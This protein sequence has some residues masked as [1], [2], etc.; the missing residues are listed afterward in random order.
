M[1][2][3]CLLLWLSSMFSCKRGSGSYRLGYPGGIRLELPISFYPSELFRR[4]GGKRKKKPR[5]PLEALYK[6][7]VEPALKEEAFLREAAW[8]RDFL[9][10]V[11]D[12]CVETACAFFYL[13]CRD[14]SI[15]TGPVSL[16]QVAREEEDADALLDTVISPTQTLSFQS[17][18][19]DDLLVLM[20]ALL[21]GTGTVVGIGRESQGQLRLLVP[22]EPEGCAL[23]LDVQELSSDGW[24][25]SAELVTSFQEEGFMDVYWFPDSPLVE[26]VEPSERPELCGE[27]VD[28]LGKWC[29]ESETGDLQKRI[30]ASILECLF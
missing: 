6:R 3:L 28:I 23:L 24:Q 25:Q 29:A 4:G 12:P 21:H 30:C 2:S 10:S 20:A 5:P 13:V 18:T 15:H 7:T 26:P 11:E 17:G 14:F 8:F 16:G 9:G 19:E 1:A 27:L 22:C